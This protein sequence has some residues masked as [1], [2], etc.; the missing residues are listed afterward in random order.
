MKTASRT[1]DMGKIILD[2]KKNSIAYTF[3]KYLNKLSYI[4]IYRMI[5]YPVPVIAIVLM[6]AQ[7]VYATPTSVYAQGGAYSKGYNDSSCDAVLCN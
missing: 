7:H 2:K 5:K 3:G 1:Y 4:N 6:G